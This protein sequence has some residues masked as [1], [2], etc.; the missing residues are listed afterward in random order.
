MSLLDAKMPN[1]VPSASFYL[2][3]FVVI[4]LQSSDLDLFACCETRSVRSV[5]PT[6]TKTV[7]PTLTRLLDYKMGRDFRYTI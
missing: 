4:L 1:E 7:S 6:G 5:L 3:P 2:H